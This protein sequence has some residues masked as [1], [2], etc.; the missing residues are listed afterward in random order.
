MI[1]ALLLPYRGVRPTL[2]P[3]CFVAPGATVV[4]DVTI[5]ARSSVWFGSVLRGDV[6]HIRIG[7]GSNLQDGTVVHVSRRNGPTIVGDRVVVGHRALLHACRL[8]DDSFVGMDAAV[9]DGAVVE[10]FGQ[11]AAGALLTPGKRVPSGEVWAGR[12]AR[13]MRALSEEDRALIR[14]IAAHYVEL[15]EEYRAALWE[16]R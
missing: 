14:D 6:Q 2:A 5:G 12:P 13:F 8:E 7:E 11:L 4:G 1:G 16:G 15:A 10:S 3:D 9:M